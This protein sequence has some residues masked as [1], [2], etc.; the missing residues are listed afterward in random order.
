MFLFSSLAEE[1]ESQRSCHLPEVA[2][3]VSGRAG[4]GAQI[5]LAVSLSSFL[6]SLRQAKWSGGLELSP[7]GGCRLGRSREKHLQEEEAAS[8]ITAQRFHP[9]LSLHLCMCPEERWPQGLQG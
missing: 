7:G 9:L 5:G 6:G 2:K 1:A 4:T 3:K 8:S